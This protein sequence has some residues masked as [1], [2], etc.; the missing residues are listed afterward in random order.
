MNKYHNE[1]KILR[2]KRASVEKSAST[3][4]KIYLLWNAQLI[5]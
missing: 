1:S 3:L 5:K 4:A 2:K